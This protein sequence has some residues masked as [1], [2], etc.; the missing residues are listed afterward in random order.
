MGPGLQDLWTRVQSMKTRPLCVFSSHSSCRQ[1]V[2]GQSS[3][4]VDT[5]YLSTDH[6]SVKIILFPQAGFDAIHRYERLEP[7]RM[8][9][10]MG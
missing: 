8:E 4:G 1:P 3:D 9:K 5:S 6:C 2:P 10:G 7:T